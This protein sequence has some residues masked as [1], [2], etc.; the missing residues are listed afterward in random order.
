[1]GDAGKN[2]LR[3]LIEQA[4]KDRSKLESAEHRG[5]VEETIELLDKGKL[6]VATRGEDG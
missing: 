1:M 6:R 2:Q 4:F 3:P 5:A